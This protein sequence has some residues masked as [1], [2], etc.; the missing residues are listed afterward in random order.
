MGCQAGEINPHQQTVVC[1]AMTK[2]KL[3]VDPFSMDWL[4]AWHHSII[5]L[6]DS[7]D[8]NLCATDYHDLIMKGHLKSLDALI[9]NRTVFPLLTKAYK[10]IHEAH[11]EL[12]AR[13][14]V[15]QFLFDACWQCGIQLNPRRSE[16]EVKRPSKA[17]QTE[18]L[19]D[20]NRSVLRLARQIK[21]LSPVLGSAGSI[22]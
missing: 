2:P 3:S 19:V 1:L 14:S 4:T 12:K 6:D 22:N 8:W 9:R 13:Q 16:W 18:E 17:I 21:R 20:L 5:D 10:K 7:G 15:R 11:G